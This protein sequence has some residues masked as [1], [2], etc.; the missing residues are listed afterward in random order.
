MKTSIKFIFFLIAACLANTAY[1]VSHYYDAA[2]RLIQIAY[3][4]GSGI[5]YVYDDNDNLLSTTTVPIPTPPQ[6]LITSSNEDTGVILNW[7]ASDGSED[8]RIYRR[9]GAN[10]AWQEISTV[11]SGTIAFIDTDTAPNTEYVYRIVAAGSLGLSAYSE[12][13][14]AISP[15]LNIF[16]ARLL[17]SAAGADLYELRFPGKLGATYRIESSNTLQSGEWSLQGY[18]I[19][20]TGP[21]SQ[22][23]IP[24]ID[25]E[26]TVF[27]SVDQSALP[28]FF[29]VIKDPE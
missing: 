2:G 12:P 28:R 1:P 7:E 23:P 10:L 19:S 21:D 20:P 14:S 25:S 3:P 24:G 29:R 18:R 22:L 6:N 17:Q 16:S 4:E 27:F 8:Y 5:T 15:N 9:R 26:M 11:P 13:S